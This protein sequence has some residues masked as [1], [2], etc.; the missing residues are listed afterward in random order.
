MKK[1]VYK[2]INNS[3][4]IKK[5]KIEFSLNFT[6]NI[7]VYGYGSQTRNL[8]HIEVEDIY[9]DDSEIADFLFRV[10]EN[11]QGIYYLSDVL[12]SVIEDFLDN[13]KFYDYINELPNQLIKENTNYKLTLTSEYINNEFFENGK[14]C[15]IK[16]TKISE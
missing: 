5:I 6:F 10:S 7:V 1:L 14:D 16:I 13:T 12:E 15:L 2:I 11:N 3:D 9:T 4:D 8:R